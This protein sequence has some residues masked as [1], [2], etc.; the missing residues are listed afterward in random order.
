MYTSSAQYS[1][2]GLG[3]MFPKEILKFR[4]YES[5]SEVI[6]DHHNHCPLR[7]NSLGSFYGGWD[8]ATLWDSQDLGIVN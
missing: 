8:Y 3:G 6:R 5:A 4:P 2:G 1:R 7:Y